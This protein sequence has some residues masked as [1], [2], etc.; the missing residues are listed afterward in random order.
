MQ[1]DLVD[2]DIVAILTNGRHTSCYELEGL[3]NWFLECTMS[4]DSLPFLPDTTAKVS[5]SIYE[6]II[7]AAR[8]LIERFDEEDAQGHSGNSDHTKKICSHRNPECDES[9]KSSRLAFLTVPCRSDP[10]RSPRRES[11]GFAMLADDITDDQL[12]AML[13][14]A[15]DMDAALRN[16]EITEDELLDLFGSL[17]RRRRSSRR[18]RRTSR[19]RSR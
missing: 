5:S 6:Q 9:Q 13:P 11:P 1:T 8:S 19:R 12:F 16:D 17:S 15:E 14:Y 2:D 10:A 7:Y 3:A 4:K 18:R